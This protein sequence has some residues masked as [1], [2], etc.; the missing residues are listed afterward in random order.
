MR[1]V[2]VGGLKSLSI[3]NIESTNEAFST[4]VTTKREAVKMVGI[5]VR[6]TLRMA[7]KRQ[8]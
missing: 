7:V 3:V 5:I 8:S 6:V 1:F 4:I 2:F